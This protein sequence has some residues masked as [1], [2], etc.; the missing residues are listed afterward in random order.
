MINMSDSVSWFVGVVEDRMD[1][2]QQGRV[3][4]RVVGLHPPQRAQGD[5]MGIPTDK[6]PWMSVIQPITSA[7]MSGIGGSVTG[8]VEGTRVYG[9]FLDK[10]KTN[11][12]IILILYSPNT[13]NYRN[14]T[15]YTLG[16][17]SMIWTPTIIPLI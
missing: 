13:I 10:W 6:L 5:V 3:R 14:A 9:H 4:V 2:L 1:P 11:G 17:I 15:W 12:I 16:P 7:A 8:P